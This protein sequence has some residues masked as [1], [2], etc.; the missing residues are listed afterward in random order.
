MALP[1]DEDTERVWEPPSE[2]RF[3]NPV[4]EQG[5]AS[6]S[7]LIDPWV[8]IEQGWDELG[9]VR[10]GSS[11]PASQEGGVYLPLPM[12]TLGNV[13]RHFLLSHLVAGVLGVLLVPSGEKPG[14]LPNILQYPGQPPPQRVI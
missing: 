7:V 13:R 2:G 4:W 3:L 11:A 14:M 8:S 10:M 6:K 1:E 9:G 12:G 5:T